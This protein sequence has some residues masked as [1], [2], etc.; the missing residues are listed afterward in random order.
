MLAVVLAA[1]LAATPRPVPEAQS[2]IF[3]PRLDQTSGVIAFMERA[4]ERSVLM[5]PSTWFSEFHPLLYV[6][7]TRPESFAAVGLQQKGSATVSYRKDG[8][9]TCV[10]V[11]D[12]KVFEARAK[13]K[14]GTLGA[15]STTKVKGVPVVVAK[16]PSDLV[17]AGYA[18]SGPVSCAFSSEKDGK[19]L[20]ALAADA[21]K[22]PAVTGSWKH[23]AKT[24]GEVVM[25]MG[26]F[27]AG[28]NGT[29]KTL[30]VEG[31]ASQLPVP[32]LRKAG[33]SPYAV[34][35]GRGIAVARAT[36]AKDAAPGALNMLVRELSRFCGGCSVAVGAFE[37][38]IGPELT[39]EVAIGVRSLEVRGRLRT[40]AQ[41]FF[42]AKQA[43]FAEVG[44]R[45]RANVALK[46]LADVP[47]AQA[48]EDGYTLPLDG[49]QVQVG[50]RGSHLYLSNDSVALASL[51]RSQKEGKTTH[52]ATFSIGPQAL[53]NALARISLF[54]VVG[55]SAELAGLFAAGTELGPVLTVTQSLTGWA[56]GSGAGQ[57]FGIEWV[58]KD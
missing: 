44:S 40:P 31:I 26:D 18:L 33:S 53:A 22:K 2:G 9:M 58:L 45:D 14:L 39:G 57:R 8:R 42:A 19:A 1:T 43:W 7:F 16:G 27:V 47:G 41:R 20:I 54:D 56:D 13:E 25:V 3:V 30:S 46:K 37:K 35:D 23:V 55:G 34:L 12:P 28:L 4:G 51:W 5:R 36:L 38:A 11:A 15:V 21:V 50:L 32:A 29:T 49:G 10:E 52:A 6:D 24:R 48:T 17:V